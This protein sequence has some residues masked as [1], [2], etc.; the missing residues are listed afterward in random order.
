MIISRIPFFALFAWLAS[1]QSYQYDAAGRLIRVA[2][3]DG[4]GFLY[5][6]DAS[7]NLLSATPIAVPLPPASIAAVAEGAAARLT[8]PPVAGAVRYLVF[9][10]PAGSSQWQEIASVTQP[11]FVDSSA[12]ASG[13]RYRIATVGANGRSAESKPVFPSSPSALQLTVESGGGRAIRSLGQAPTTQSGYALVDVESGSNPYGV[14][15]FQL[16]QNGVVVSEAAVPASPPTEAARIFY[17]Y[18]PNLAA[19]PSSFAGQFRGTV[20]VNTGFGAANPGTVTANMR[21]TLRDVEGRVAAT[22]ATMLP[23][24][25]Q[26]ARLVTD[27]P[28]LAIPGF[29][30]LDIESDQP[31]SMMALRVTSNQR[32]EVL[33]TSTPIA[34][35][36]ATHDHAPSYFPHFAD[37]GGFTTALILLNT[38]GGRQSGLIEFFAGDGAPLVVTPLIGPASSR[39]SYSIPPDGVIILESDGAEAETRAGWI[40]LVPDSGQPAPDGAGIFR[41]ARLGTLVS[42]S[43]IPAAKP[44]TRALVYV[45]RQQG[46][47]TGIAIA[48]PGSSRVSAAFRAPNMP[49][50][51]VL[52]PPQGHSAD[53]AGDILG[54]L[55]PDFRGVLEVTAPSPILA[56]TLRI[57]NNARGDLLMST[58][59]VADQTR[60][61]PAPVYFPHLAD[62]GGFQTELIVFG[63]LSPAQTLIRFYGSSG[64]PLPIARI[65]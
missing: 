40:R 45:D 59:P 27:F 3:P 32:G 19:A 58:I 49:S 47:D 28:G 2:N 37:G 52:L 51:S 17:E 16:T 9:R 24:G 63:P 38:S 56:L 53:L 61:A 44:T 31:I 5:S 6:Y 26:F 4:T 1:A 18:R 10:Q 20:D 13:A 25:G 22:S 30:S 55:P 33:F 54:Q 21:L 23:P 12:A 50:A 14:A 48:N 65:P 36:P 34:K 29:G 62:G 57:Q 39:F 11:S 8:W 35:L 43:G 15:I 64:D 42:E 46:R 60:P 7:D 41:F